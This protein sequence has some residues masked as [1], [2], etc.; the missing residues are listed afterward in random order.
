MGEISKTIKVAATI[1][2]FDARDTYPVT[3]PKYGKGSLRTVE[4]NIE[5]M[6][7]SNGRREEGMIVY[8]KDN[9]EYYTLVGGI[10]NSHWKVVLILI[11]DTEGNINIQGNL[12]ATLID[13]GNF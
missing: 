12:N 7:I 10:T 13:G 4:N 11:P 9:A 3:N 8:Q 5:R 6:T 2:P 1:A